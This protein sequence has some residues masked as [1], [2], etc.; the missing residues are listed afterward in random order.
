MTSSPNLA[1][2]LAHDGRPAMQDGR[3]TDTIPSPPPRD[4]DEAALESRRIEAR[5]SDTIP[6]PGP[7]ADDDAPSTERAPATLGQVG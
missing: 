2:D 5:R 3:K 1:A 6:A 7:D 4:A